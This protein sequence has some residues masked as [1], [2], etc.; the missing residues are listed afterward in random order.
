MNEREIYRHWER[1]AD[2][3]LCLET[4][5]GERIEVI[6]S[7]KRNTGAGPDYTG[8]ILEFDDEIWTGDVE[9]H[10]D[11]EDW[12]K[13]GHHHDSAFDDVQLHFFLHPASREIA[14]DQVR[15]TVEVDPAQLQTPGQQPVAFDGSGQTTLC[16]AGHKLH[17]APERVSNALQVIER[18]GW[19]RL[20]RQKQKVRSSWTSNRRLNTLSRLLCSSLGLHD[21]REQARAVIKTVDVRWLRKRL[22]SIDDPV[23]SQRFGEGVLL[24]SAGL[25]DVRFQKKSRRTP[26][27]WKRYK[28]Q[29]I[30]RIPD[31]LLEQKEYDW[32][33]SDVRPVNTPFRRLAGFVALFRRFFV[34]FSVEQV[35]TFLIHRIRA[36]RNQQED[37]VHVSDLFNL[38]TVEPE[39]VS[40]FWNCHS[41]PEQSLSQ[42]MALIGS[43]RAAILLLNGLFPYMLTLAEERNDKRL[44]T[45]LRKL[46]HTASLPLGDRR[47]RTV[48]EQL[49]GAGSEGIR[50]TGVTDQGMHELFSSFC[51]YGPGGC[52]RC[53]VHDSVR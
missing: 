21:N 48:K 36:I 43:H 19:E 12:L 49:F 7:G 13:H 51:R 41:H 10:V 27:D 22:R 38:L 39:D 23:Q 4:N 47:T 52:S 46:M 50:Q 31:F 35:E 16:P 33:V 11:E 2:Q 3:K 8:C 24:S 34:R 15:R 1:G 30:Q 26:G 9:I 53:P 45:D 42:P 17:S 25:L 28:E 20:Q 37:Q 40:S 5:R 18:M 14:S 29:V 44:Q 32:E 6:G